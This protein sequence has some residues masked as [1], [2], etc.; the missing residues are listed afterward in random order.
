MN[1]LY[2]ASSLVSG[3]ISS[4]AQLDLS[5]YSAFSLG[6]TTK[7]LLVAEFDKVELIVYVNRNRLFIEASTNNRFDYL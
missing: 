2:K 1:T 5:I 4:N 6:A 7:Q 3:S